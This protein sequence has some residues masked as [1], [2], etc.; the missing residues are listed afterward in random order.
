MSS[1]VRTNGEVSKLLVLVL[2]FMALE[3]PFLGQG[4][5]IP[6]TIRANA[7]RGHVRLADNGKVVPEGAVH[8]FRGAG[9]SGEAIAV[10]QTDESGFFYIPD[11]APGRY[12]LRAGW[13]SPEGGFIYSF[14]FPLILSGGGNRESGDD[15][16][17]LVSVAL[18][19]DG[20]PC[21]G[22]TASVK[23]GA[24]DGL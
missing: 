5:C 15:V 9:T 20:D 4:M 12:W 13:T 8:V 19:P 22:S 7:I 23:S 11:M 24:K 14:S 1:I 21:R 3:R 6:P 16:E 10:A 18:H 2:L 17:V